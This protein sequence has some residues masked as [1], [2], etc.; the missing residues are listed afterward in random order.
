MALPDSVKHVLVID[1]NP[2]IR[3]SICK[4]KKKKGTFAIKL[5]NGVAAHEKVKSNHFEL[6]VADHPMPLMNGIEFL[7]KLAKKKE[8]PAP[9]I[10][11]LM[12]T[13]RDKEVNKQ[14]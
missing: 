2:S 14:G 6:I 3:P 11:I 12:P 9:R 8:S 13:G 1:D 10:I 7:K 4:A 5:Y